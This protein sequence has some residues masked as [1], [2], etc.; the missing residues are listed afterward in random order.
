RL[1]LAG[2]LH[3]SVLPAMFKV[4]LMGQVMR[5]DL[6]E[7]KLLDLEDDLPPLNE[8]IS[9]AQV[10]VRGVTGGLR[11][12]AVG[13][14]GLASSLRSLAH[15][16]EAASSTRFDLDLEEVTA[17]DTIQLVTYHVGREAMMNASKH[18]KCERVAV[19]LHQSNDGIDLRIRDSG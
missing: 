4:Q 11:G 8:A 6:A 14:G 16:L 1:V 3:D 12:S 15:E 18:S 9:E 10:R 2:E 13:P 19:Q 17:S 5:Q 7:G